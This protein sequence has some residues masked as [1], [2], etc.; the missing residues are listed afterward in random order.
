MILRFRR[1]RLPST[2]RFEDSKDGNS[3]QAQLVFSTEILDV[4]IVVIFGG[5]GVGSWEVD[6]AEGPADLE[7][8]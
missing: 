2:W 5:A 8:S 7:Q 4:F 1:F 6:F 3:L